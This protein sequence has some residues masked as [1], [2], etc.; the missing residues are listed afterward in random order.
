MSQNRTD[1]K[2][3]ISWNEEMIRKYDPD[4]YHNHPSWIIRTIEQMRCRTVRR[5]FDDASEKSILD[6]GCGAGNLI[7]Y[8]GGFEYTGVDISESIL[9]KAARRAHDKCTLVRALVEE[10]PFSDESVPNLFC[11]EVIEHV[12]EPCLV[13]REAA[14]VLKPDGIAVF[15]I[16]NEKLINA[17]KNMIPRIGT[18]RNGYR[19]PKRMDDEWHLTAFDSRLFESIV[20]GLFRIDNR[21]GVPSVLAPVRYVFKLKKL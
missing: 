9:K 3:F 10:L 19:A 12:V 13:I 17:I 15:T 20:N 6:M 1:E 14:R 2:N 8:F 4:E 18:S 16:P 5:M 7:P 11:S 21:V